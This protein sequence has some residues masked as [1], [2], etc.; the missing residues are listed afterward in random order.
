MELAVLAI[1]AQHAFIYTSLHE[2]K[3]LPAF[4]T[5][6]RKVAGSIPDEVTDFF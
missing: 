2:S 1:S 6:S 5:T 4:T 3:E